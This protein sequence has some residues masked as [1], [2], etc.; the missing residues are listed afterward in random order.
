MSSRLTL[1][2]KELYRWDYMTYSQMRNRLSK[3]TKREKLDCF[4][5]VANSSDFSIIE[6]REK[7]QL[8]IAACD[9]WG[10]LF[11]E[12]HTLSPETRR[13]SSVNQRRAAN[14]RRKLS[15]ST[16]VY[17]DGMPLGKSWEKPKR[18]KEKKKEKPF[19]PPIRVIR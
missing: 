18:M 2:E 9:R 5:Q 3:I 6:D 12:P 4:I 1:M 8:L 10:R 11:G 13:V 17:D 7:E 19:V 14:R 15:N 16:E